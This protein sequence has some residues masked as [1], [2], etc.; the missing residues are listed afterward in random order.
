MP[1]GKILERG[2]IDLIDGRHREFRLGHRPH[3][4]GAVAAFEDGP[5][6]QH[7]AWTAM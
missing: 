6:A 3:G 5:I 1:R 7:G 4:G 2:S